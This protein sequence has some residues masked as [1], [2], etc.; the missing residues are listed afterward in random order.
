MFSLHKQSHEELRKT[1]KLRNKSSS[2]WENW[3]GRELSHFEAAKDLAEKWLSPRPLIPLQD[4][5]GRPHLTGDTR[6]DDEGVKV[7]IGPRGHGRH[8]NGQSVAKYRAPKRKVPLCD[9]AG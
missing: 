1:E 6:I 9:K 7:T 5:A 3:C 2:Y 4:P 8:R